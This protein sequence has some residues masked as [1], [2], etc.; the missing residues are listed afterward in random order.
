[1]PP[2]HTATSREGREMK[3][4]RFGPVVGLPESFPLV[5][6]EC[7]T[8]DYTGKKL[9]RTALGK[10]TEQALGSLSAEVHARSSHGHLH[11]DDVKDG[12]N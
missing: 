5:P 1:M 7:G 10:H 8:G 3:M 4:G 2:G 6:L 11:V 9:Q 12:E